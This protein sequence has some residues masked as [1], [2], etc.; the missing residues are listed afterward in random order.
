MTASKKI[1]IINRLKSYTWEEL[2]WLEQQCRLL[3]KSADGIRVYRST[4]LG[5]NHRAV[6]AL[7]DWFDDCAHKHGIY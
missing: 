6:D 2:D 1:K 4:D 7:S 5:S 3:K